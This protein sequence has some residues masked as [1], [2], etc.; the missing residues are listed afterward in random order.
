MGRGFFADLESLFID[1]Y[2]D[3]ARETSGRP[4]IFLDPD[5]FNREHFDK[6][7]NVHPDDLV[8]VREMLEEQMP[9][10]TNGLTAA[11]LR[12]AVVLSLTS[13]PFA[14]PAEIKPPA[15]STASPIPICVVNEQGS[16]LNHKNE[17]LPLLARQDLERIREI[18]GWDDHWD[19]I[20]G[21]HEGTHCN[22]PPI[23][24]TGMTHD[25]ILVATLGRE[26]G[27]DQAAINWARANGLDDMAQAMIDIRALGAADD[28]EHATAILID[29]SGP[30][31]IDHINAARTFRGE[32]INKVAA[33]QGISVA[34]AT[35]MLNDRPEEFNGH[36]KKLLADGAFDGNSNPHVKESI[37]A[38]SGAVQ[39]QITDRRIERELEREHGPHHHG[40][41]EPEH[42]GESETQLASNEADNK[43][44]E[45]AALESPGFVPTPSAYA[46][47]DV[48]EIDGGKVEV[49]LRDEGGAS[50][51]IG[52]VSAPAFF[53]SHADNDLALQR[54]A[55]N[56]GMGP[57]L[58]RQFDNAAPAVSTS[59]YG[60]A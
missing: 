4:V 5:E 18:P 40:A 58:D 29:K 9:G 20:I 43:P 53:A 6:T 50:Q 30:A 35:T 44:V 55:L 23:N 11:D 12:T 13:G 56:E 2:K 24:T 46:G 42:A 15:G 31:T 36:I 32:M 33:D 3:G 14:A 59:T 52:G 49:A 45:T 54:I 19:R 8:K 26:A 57:G 34:D 48:R 28:P 10:I 7:G 21:I 1:D 39:R 47:M 17:L 16:S 60:I 27:A 22:Q 38:F 51:R 25:Q 37:E 41:L